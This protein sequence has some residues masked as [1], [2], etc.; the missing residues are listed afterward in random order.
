ML[1]SQQPFWVRIRCSGIVGCFFQK[2]LSNCNKQ[3]FKMA[4]VS[5]SLDNDFFPFF[6][7]SVICGMLRTVQKA[8]SPLLSAHTDIRKM[9]LHIASRVVSGLEV[10]EG[11]W[12]CYE[13]YRELHLFEF[14]VL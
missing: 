11:V 12:I 9:V 2:G 3:I 7:F 1:D 5:S 10:R 14:C 6:F 8:I 13:T 4:W